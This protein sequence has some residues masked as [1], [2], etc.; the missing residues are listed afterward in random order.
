MFFLKHNLKI[1][2]ISF[3]ENDFHRFQQL[4]TAALTAKFDSSVVSSISTWGA[5]VELTH[6]QNDNIIQK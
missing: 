4:D 5:Q 2:R 6:E 3:L 1:V